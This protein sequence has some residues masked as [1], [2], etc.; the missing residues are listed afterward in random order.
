MIQRD[1]REGGAVLRIVLDAPK[2]N[3]LDSAMI[4]AIG[5]ALEADV[6]AGTKLIVFEGAGK[7]FCFGASV[8]E[9]RR[10]AAPA[11]L[12]AFHGLFRQLARLA[13]PTCA[14]VRGQCLGGGLELA[15][16]CTFL[17]A[18]P[19]ARLGQPE[20]KLAVFPP[21]ASLLL[22][23]R[24]G[25]GAALDLCVTGRSVDAAEAQ[26]MGLVN[27]VTDDPEA[28]VSALFAESLRPTSA[29]S[30]RFAERAARADLMRRLER[31]LPELERLYLDELMT[32]HDANEGIAAFL[33]RRAPQHRNA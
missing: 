30:L 1:K 7:H 12:A 32:T 14:I 2:A 17:V 9:H 3:I 24:L 4:R 18:T 16:Y 28:W 19:E 20:I 29:S 33:E 31:D 5:G 26:R 8:E 11:M 15:A 21:M 6:E 27:A 25:G 13:V 10:D 23:W 22:P